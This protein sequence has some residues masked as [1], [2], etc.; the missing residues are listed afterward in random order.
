MPETKVPGSPLHLRGTVLPGGQDR[1][2]Y[3]VDGRIT[4][5]PVPAA[6]T[7]ASGEWVVPGLVDA[8]A[9]L[10][11]ASPVPHAA[12]EERVRASAQAQLGAGVLLVREP[13]SPDRASAG[14]GNDDGLPR[15]VTG[16]RFLA[17]PGGYVPGLAREVAAA[18]LPGAVRQ[19]AEASGAWAKVIG[20]FFASTGEVVAHW[21]QETLRRAAE[22]AHAE[23]ARIAIHA[24]RPDVI[25]KAI[26]AGFDSIEHGTGLT[27]ELAEAMAEHR[28]TLVPTMIIGEGIL[29]WRRML[30]A[31]R[32]SGRY[33]VGWSTTRRR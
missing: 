28:A 10:S 16:G 27:P 6:I 33:A 26:R 29:A 1:D 15:V 5:E 9:H 13:G 7:V 23:G 32:V 25:E 24:T 12:A 11:I 19:E 8:H 2:V 21:D 22:A 4:F 14:L 30:A 18:E 17:P 20:D 3:V 31:R